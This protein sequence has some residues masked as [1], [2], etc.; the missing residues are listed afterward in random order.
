MKTIRGGKRVNVKT[1]KQRSASSGK[2][3][4]QL[5]EEMRQAGREYLRT[6]PEAFGGGID[7]QTGARTIAPSPTVT[8]QTISPSIIQ[9]TIQPS[10]KKIEPNISG[11]LFSSGLGY[12]VAP[13]YQKQFIKEMGTTPI[14]SPTLTQRYQR[15]EKKASEKLYDVFG[16]TKE[17][18]EQQRQRVLESEKFLFKKAGEYEKSLRVMGISDY[19]ARAATYPQYIA[20]KSGTLIAGAG[21]GIASST[22]EKPIK[23]VA[24]PIALAGVGY[25]IPFITTGATALIGGTGG[26]AATGAFGG[27]VSSLAVPTVKLGATALGLSWLGKTGLQY[28]QQPTSF[29]EGELLGKTL[30]EAGAIGGGMIAGK[31]RVGKIS[32]WLRTRGRTEIP[33]EDIIIPDVLSGKT[34]FVESK[35]YG[36][37]GTPGISKQKFDI[38]VFKEK[39]YSYHVTPDQ[40]WKDSFTTVKGTSE[41]PGL[42]TAPSPSIYFGKVAPGK[43]PYKVS[44]FGTGGEVGKPSVA[45]VYTDFTI[46]PK[47]PGA[48]VTGVKPEIEAVIPVGKTFSKVSG[49]IFFRFGGRKIPIDVF[50]PTGTLSK[51]VSGG[52]GIGG[53]SS[54][55]SIPS[56]SI[57]SPIT[58]TISGI[59]SPYV[60]PIESSYIVS[61][62][63]STSIIT[64]YKSPPDPYVPTSMSTPSK[65]SPS[66][67]SVWEPSS[68]EYKPTPPPPSGSDPTPP[69]TYDWEPTPPPPIISLSK[70]LKENKKKKGSSFIPQV[71]SKGRWLSVG[72]RMDKQ[73]A[74][75]RASKGVDLTT[76]RRMRIFPSNKPPQITG[77]GGWGLRQHKF[78]PHRIKRGRKIPLPNQYIE[79]TTYAI[80]TPTEVSGL[81]IAKLTKNMGW[82][83]QTSKIKSVRK[84]TRVLNKKKTKRKSQWLV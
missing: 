20:A 76:S 28:T 63:I 78:R 40:Y 9:P 83:S 37:T 65:P 6:H 39:P 44:L 15:A 30:L 36:Y 52:V 77:I 7:P 43:T 60:S 31:Q 46:K 13:Q 68:Y 74:L 5:I 16:F 38:K 41:F 34:R 62:Q 48:F 71:L 23:S 25:S 12:S 45:Q 27:G 10:A 73:S 21:G 84:A 47:T 22:L 64:S 54:I 11:E 14:P 35:S 49:D 67:P 69:P 17:Q 70:R 4:Q 53:S 32:D 75:S 72:K 26:V 59:S 19:W 24:T 82:L 18:S 29:E 50:K 2:N 57:Y 56:Y 1:S 81:S 8:Q 79:K 42:Y 61:P 80:D 3:E 33:T 66:K 55:Y 51:G 58:T